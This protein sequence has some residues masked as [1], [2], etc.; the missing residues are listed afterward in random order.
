MSF[1][2]DTMRAK[3]KTCKAVLLVL[4]LV[5]V[6]PA[7]QAEL[8]DITLKRQSPG[9]GDIPPAIFPHWIH[10]MQFKCAVCHDELFK[11]K[12]GSSNITMRDI[13]AGKSCGVCHN[14]KRAFSP[15]FA[16]C[17]HCHRK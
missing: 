4:T 14:G 12:A 15:T 2:E 9:M 5:V 6:A 16:V 17:S 8:G 11:M 1:T 13:Q 3:H 10:R 7:L